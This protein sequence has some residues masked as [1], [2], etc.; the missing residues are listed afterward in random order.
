MTFSDLW[1]ILRK[2]KAKSW[3]IPPNFEDKIEMEEKKQFEREERRMQ[4]EMQKL[5]IEE[6]KRL[7]AKKTFE[8][9]KSSLN[10]TPE[11][12]YDEDYEDEADDDLAMFTSIID[13]I[14]PQNQNTGGSPQ[15]SRNTPTLQ[16][17][18]STSAVSVSDEDIRSFIK[19][20]K[21]YNISVAKRMKKAEVVARAKVEMGLSEKDAERAYEIM[22]KEF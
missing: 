22:I 20:Q 5:Q 12:E 2:P 4:I 1:K 7:Q 17:T 15:I 3:I 19:Q 8:D 10:I 6:T 9:I 16:A 11:D 21:P 14:M 13:R 18:N